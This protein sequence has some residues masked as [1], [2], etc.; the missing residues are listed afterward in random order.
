MAGIFAF[1]V[2]T[3]VVLPLICGFGSRAAERAEE[4]ELASHGVIW[5]GEEAYERQV[6]DQM[7]AVLMDVRARYGAGRPGAGRPRAPSARPTTV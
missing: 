1:V 2:L 4:Q 5:P 6:A 3:L 7:G